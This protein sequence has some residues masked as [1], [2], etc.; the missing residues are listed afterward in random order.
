MEPGGMAVKT[1]TIP[2]VF[3]ETQ[4]YGFVHFEAALTTNFV[5]LKVNKG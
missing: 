3:N 2:A 1:T 4:S 5:V